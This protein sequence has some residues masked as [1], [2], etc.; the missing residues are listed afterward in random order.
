VIKSYS[1][2]FGDDATASGINVSH[3]YESEGVYTVSLT[4]TDNRGAKDSD[5]C[6]IT[7]RALTANEIMRLPNS[8]AASYLTGLSS[9]DA[10]EI[11]MEVDIPAAADIFEEMNTTVAVNMLEAAVSLNQTDVVSKIMLETEEE[12]SAALLIYV[13]PNFGR[14]VV[15]SMMVIDETDCAR[16]VEMAVEL[17]VLSIA[18]VLEG[19]E[20]DLLLELLVEISMLPLTPSTVADL[21]K[22]M[23]LNKALE[24]IGSWV[25]NEALPELG[26]VL[27]YLT[28]ETL[29]NVYG[30][31]TDAERAMVFPYLSPETIN[32]ISIELLPLPDV[33]PIFIT[34]SQRERLGYSVTVV[35]ENQGSFDSGSL[36]VYLEVNAQV[37]EQIEIEN[38]SPETSTI[39]YYEWEP[40]LEGIY[41][42]KVMVDPDN[43]VDEVVE[44]NNELITI[45]GVELP[46]LTVSV[47][48]LPMEL[49]EKETYTIEVEVS[50]IGKE[51]SSG[52]DLTVEASGITKKAQFTS[53]TFNTSDV[54]ELP[55]GS[56]RSIQFLWTPDEAGI[57]TLKATIDTQQEVLEG[58]ETNNIDKMKVTIEGRRRLWPL[59]VVSFMAVMIILTVLIFLFKRTLPF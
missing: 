15:E 1:W 12:N 9:E 34:V 18:G 43:F 27:G 14:R 38:L 45:Y 35:I 46:D 7:I 42:I 20:T 33:T 54:E 58:D 13:E 2:D 23:S 41:T 11:L 40:N 6:I 49:F 48:T 50:N 25:S 57:Y 55:P 28:P 37:M 30:G 44:T 36:I 47:K 3:V 8:E 31:L 52:I 51:D 4:V 56:S 39:V 16:L 32:A 5:T 59:I 17:D 21:F 29:N 24:V 53:I 19:V 10:F 22:V 26:S